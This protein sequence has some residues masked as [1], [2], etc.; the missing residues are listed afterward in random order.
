VNTVPFQQQSLFWHREPPRSLLTI[1]RECREQAESMT[2][3]Q[4]DQWY[5]EHVGYRLTEEGYTGPH[6]ATVMVAGS[7]FFARCPNGIE[8]PGAQAME[9]TLER[10]IYMGHPL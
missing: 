7:M 6:E 1:A 5:F 3:V 8:T 10:S 2:G 4:L 9:S